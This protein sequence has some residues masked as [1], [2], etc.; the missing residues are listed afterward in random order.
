[1]RRLS[2][3]AIALASTTVTAASA[4]AFCAVAPAD[5][6]VVTAEVQVKVEEDNV[7]R[8]AFDPVISKV[9][10]WTR[11]TFLQPAL[12][13]NTFQIGASR[14]S[15]RSNASGIPAGT[16]TNQ[17][18]VALRIN[19]GLSHI[20]RNL[21][22][23]LADEAGLD[24]I[25]IISGTKKLWSA[26]G[27][28]NTYSLKLRDVS[29]DL[30]FGVNS[31]DGDFN[32]GRKVL[33][34]LDLQSAAAHAEL[35]FKI[36]GKS[37]APWYCA[38]DPIPNM[39]LEASFDVSDL[40]GNLDATLAT[41]GS[42][43]Q[44]STID[45]IE[46]AVAHFSWDTNSWLVDTIL[47]LGF[48]L[49]DLFDFSCSGQSDCLSEAVNRYALGDDDFLDQ[50]TA[51]VN[52]AID[53]PLTINT[54]VSTDAFAAN[55]S[56]SLNSLKSSTAENTMTS[57]WDVALSSA[58]ASNACASALTARAYA[59]EGSTGDASLT[60]NDFDLEVPFHYLSKIAYFAGLQGAFCRTF[61]YTVL[62]RARTLTMKPNGSVTISDGDAAD[63]SNGVKIA[64]PVVV[65]MSGATGSIAGTLTVKGTLGI[66][67]GSD[68]VFTPTS[69]DV[70]ALSG[71]VTISGVTVSAAS[72]EPTI[73]AAASALVASIGS[74]ELMN[75]VVQTGIAGVSISVGEVVSTT[76][77]LVVG[78]DLN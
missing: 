31:V 28:C 25:E 70:S 24:H 9:G 69:A 11:Q 55:F 48:A 50:M 29:I 23:E 68:L 54:G 60:I 4:P 53:G 21:V 61:S 66:D 52:D 47:D 58:G 40:T 62:G 76:G 74:L 38:L 49:Y 7:V 51:L 27:D 75:S 1:M 45:A 67:G 63:P 56:V 78:L 36:A 19:D 77:A 65:A 64:L 57:I 15:V 73:D 18:K 43:I 34:D 59:F 41:S 17:R 42:A 37:G 46:M 32:T 8:D 72:L 14:L 33:T 44:I 10:A 2:S 26:T 35:V 16:V 30:P 39:E 13:N 6:P 3:L 22:P 20:G 5:S 12:V 71:S